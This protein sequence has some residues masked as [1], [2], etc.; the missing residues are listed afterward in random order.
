[1]KKALLFLFA[2]VIISCNSSK[3]IVNKTEN[4]TPPAY[5]RILFVTD[6]Y[7]THKN[8]AKKLFDT[9]LKNNLTISKINTKI[10]ETA[11]KQLLDQNKYADFYLV[12]NNLDKTL[13]LSEEEIQQNIDGELLDKNIDLLII[14]HQNN[15]TRYYNKLNF[16]GDVFNQN[17]Y[18]ATTNSNNLEYTYTFTGIDV[19]QDSIVFKSKYQVQNA[20]DLFNNIPKH[21]A[22]KLI[23]QLNEQHLY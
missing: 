4:S 21:V 12:K 16:K 14:M 10:A 6:S 9:E 3:T 18:S 8:I 2:L 19:S 13:I 23:Q 1:M 15:I 22:Q 17:S 11:K 7:Y 5:K 20:D